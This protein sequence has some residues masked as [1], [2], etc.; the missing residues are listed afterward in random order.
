LKKGKE[1]QHSIYRQSAS[2]FPD[3]S[4]RLDIEFSEAEETVPIVPTFVS[5]PIENNGKNTLDF[6][7][8][9]NFRASKYLYFSEQTSLLQSEVIEK[10]TPD[11]A[12]LLKAKNYW[13]NIYDASTLN[14]FTAH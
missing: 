13:L 8:F 7:R 6:N 4:T 14:K 1:D 9:K 5:V 2:N 3:S 12:E 11:F 10:L